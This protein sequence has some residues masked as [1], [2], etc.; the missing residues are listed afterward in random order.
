MAAELPDSDRVSFAVQADIAHDF[1]AAVY[2]I[3][4]IGVEVVADLLV[5][6]EVIQGDLFK[7][8]EAGDLLEKRYSNV[9]QKVTKFRKCGSTS[10]ECDVFLYNKIENINMSMV[11]KRS[12]SCRGSR[13]SALNVTTGWLG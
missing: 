10:L 9:R 13:R 1:L 5:V 3:L 6:G 2:P 8:Q 12:D 11:M 7:G 4:N